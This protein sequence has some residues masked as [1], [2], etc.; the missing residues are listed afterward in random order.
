MNLQTAI[1][2][3]QSSDDPLLQ[4]QLAAALEGAPASDT[5]VA[6]VSERQNAD[7]SW[8][9]RNQVGSPPSLHETC[10]WLHTLAALDEAWNESAAHASAWL[11]DQQRPRGWWRETE[12]LTQYDPPLWMHPESDDAT[13]YTTA[14]CANTLALIGEDEDLLAI[15]KAV[16][17]LQPQ[18]ASNGLL[19]GFRIHA[20]ALALPAFV[21]IG[22]AET[23][24]VK[25]ML[26]GLSDA[27]S[28]EWDTP[29]PALALAALAQAGF[30]RDARLVQRILNL[31]SLRQQPDGAWHNEDER[32]DAALTLQIVRAT[33]RAGIR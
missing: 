24:P 13:I 3:V 17:W 6:L 14:L 20:T 10:R 25:R 33:R 4:A 26:R 22:H 2:Y 31:L 28:D 16:T 12:A 9:Y 18:I 11:R 1:D 30:R 8:P 32:P 23:R 29:M 19:P 21:A 27:L 5:V 7:G 15:D